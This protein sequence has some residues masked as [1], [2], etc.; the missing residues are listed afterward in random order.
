M[1]SSSLCKAITPGPAA[2]ATGKHLGERIQQTIKPGGR[3]ISCPQQSGPACSTPP[4]RCGFIN[5][6]LLPFCNW[7]QMY[8]YAVPSPFGSILPLKILSLHSLPPPPQ[9]H[10]GPPPSVTALHLDL[11]ILAPSSSPLGWMVGLGVG[12]WEKGGSDFLPSM[13]NSVKIFLPQDV[14]SRARRSVD[15]AWF[16]PRFLPTAFS[17]GSPKMPSASRH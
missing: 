6:H 1:A 2:M 7:R 14:L 10:P 16:Q 4:G 15:T 11:T 13:L 17:A 9:P 5:S 3:P 8:S 12:G